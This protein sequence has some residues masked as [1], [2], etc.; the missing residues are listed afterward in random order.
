M[1]YAY[2][3]VGEHVYD[4]CTVKS[5]VNVDPPSSEWENVICFAPWKNVMIFWTCP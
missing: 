1:I 5:F 4:P 3:P 2:A